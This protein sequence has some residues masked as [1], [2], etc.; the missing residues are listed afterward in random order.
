MKRVN[1][2]YMAISIVGPTIAEVEQAD[3]ASHDDEDGD[4]VTCGAERTAA[5][6]TT[7]SAV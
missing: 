5:P 2:W 3:P 4:E 1:K 7:V 6:S